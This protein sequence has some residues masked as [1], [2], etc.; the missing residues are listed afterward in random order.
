MYFHLKE[1][2]SKL[3]CIWSSEYAFK[4]VKTSNLTSVGIKGD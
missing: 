2:Y 3:V 4:A 1:D